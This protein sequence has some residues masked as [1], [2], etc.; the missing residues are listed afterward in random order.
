[1]NT[2][3]NVKQKEISELNEEKKMDKD[4]EKRMEDTLRKMRKTSQ[5][6]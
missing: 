5:K 3:Q 6:E 4:R 2:K 1:M